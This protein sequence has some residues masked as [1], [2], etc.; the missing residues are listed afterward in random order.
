MGPTGR[1]LHVHMR[2][3]ANLVQVIPAEFQVRQVH[4]NQQI[5]LHLHAQPVG[6]PRLGRVPE[7]QLPGNLT[8]HLVLVLASVQNL[9]VPTL[10]HVPAAVQNKFFA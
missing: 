1:I 5:H 7:V 8:F 2:V 10:L 4:S 6:N 3:V 9:S